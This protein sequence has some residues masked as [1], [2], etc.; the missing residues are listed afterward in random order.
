MTKYRM[1][2]TA[3][4]VTAMRSALGHVFLTAP[5]NKALAAVAR[6]A[7]YPDVIDKHARTLAGRSAAGQRQW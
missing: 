4:S 6:F 7:E 3:P 1:M 5:R 2:H